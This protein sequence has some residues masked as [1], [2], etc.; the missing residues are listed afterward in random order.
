[1]KMIIGGKW[2]DKSEQ[3]NV[4]NPYDGSVVDTVPKGTEKDIT[5]SSNPR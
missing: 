5:G 2:V 4:R 3:I 1:M